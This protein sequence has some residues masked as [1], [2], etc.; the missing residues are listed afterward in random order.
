MVAVNRKSKYVLEYLANTGPL[1]KARQLQEK[2]NASVKRGDAFLK[3]IASTSRSSFSGISNNIRS[4]VEASKRLSRSFSGAMRTMRNAMVNTRFEIATLGAALA[5]VFGRFVGD[6]VKTAADTEEI[7]NRF[8]VSFQGVI[9]E[10]TVVVDKMSSSM[11]LSKNTVADYLSQAQDVLI[12]FGYSRLAALGLSK[13]ITQL[14][15]DLGSFN[16][17]PFDEALKNMLSGLLGNHNALR[18]MRVV[19]REATLE[20]KALSMGIKKGW[21]N[22]DEATKLQIRFRV[23][24]DQSVNAIGDLHR[25][26][27]E[28]TNRF[29]F[30]QEMIKNM[31]NSLFPGLTT[32]LGEIAEQLGVYILNNETMF[33][34]LGEYITHVGYILSQVSRHVLAFMNHWQQLSEIQQKLIIFAGSIALIATP[35]MG[36][37]VIFGRAMKV[38]SFWVTIIVLVALG[39]QDIYAV[40]KGGEG[41]FKDFLNY[42]GWSIEGIKKFT[43]SLPAMA[44][45]FVLGIK[46]SKGF[47]TVL[48]AVLDIMGRAWSVI[49]KDI[50]PALRMMW[51]VLSANQIIQTIFQLLYV[52]LKVFLDLVGLV[53]SIF[54]GDLG[55][56][57]EHASSFVTSVKEMLGGAFKLL[58]G[59]VGTILTKLLPNLIRG[60]FG[61]L[62][63]VMGQVLKLIVQGIVG[64]MSPIIKGVVSILSFLWNVFKT[65]IAGTRDII[66]GVFN[67]LVDVT[68]G[69]LKNAFSFLE[70]K[71]NWVIDKMAKAK[72]FITGG[73]TDTGSPGAPNPGA[74]NPGGFPGGTLP[75]DIDAGGITGGVIHSRGDTKISF[76]EVNIPIQLPEGYQGDV[77]EFRRIAAE[78]SQA[79][80]SN[81]MLRAYDSNRGR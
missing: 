27:F 78:E 49:T 43:S 31:K 68:V 32:W 80:I 77:T 19:L 47:Q 11:R 44:K 55:R 69:V 42:M 72:A 12:G 64:I 53:F 41:Y 21:N 37:I 74:P 30:F 9:T 50:I 40:M 79:A 13:E 7:L 81:I 66:L 26:M 38:M 48:T 56:I 25:T 29:R 61:F 52:G 59:V 71:V 75:P 65:F 60:L 58:L 6:G 1:K 4:A 34:D 51:D 15:L 46:N 14:S 33:S 70:G 45:S 17:I 2:F 24:V 62:V 39:M 73:S 67:V 63:S 35:V 3:L 57:Q 28:T 76:A 23:A 20:Q 5:T 8:R 22:L 16:N 18:G 54:S 36:I 10:A